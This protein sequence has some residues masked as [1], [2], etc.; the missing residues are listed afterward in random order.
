MDLLINLL[1]LV[2]LLYCLI[3]AVDLV[4]LPTP[5]RLIIRAILAIVVIIWMLRLVGYH[6]PTTLGTRSLPPQGYAVCFV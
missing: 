2:V 6:I 3:W 5:I 1:I 4:P